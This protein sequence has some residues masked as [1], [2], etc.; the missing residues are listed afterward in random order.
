MCAGVRSHQSATS[1]PT[2]RVKLL[3]G[4]AGVWRAC[5]MVQLESEML[6][7]RLQPSVGRL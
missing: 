1:F 4:R 7:W 5:S 2:C 6:A 3:R